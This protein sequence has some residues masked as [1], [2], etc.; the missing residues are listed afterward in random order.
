MASNSSDASFNYDTDSRALASID[1]PHRHPHSGSGS[2]PFKIDSRGTTSS[3]TTRAV[4]VGLVIGVIVSISNIYFGLQIGWSS[5]MSMPSS[6]LGFAAFKA[7]AKYLQLPFTQQENVFVQTVA[8]AVG[9][10]PVTAGLTGVIP[11]LEFLLSPAENGPLHFSYS[12]LLLWSL[13]LCPFGLIWAMMFRRQFVVREPLPW[14]GPVA[15]ATLISVLH[16]N[17]KAS[18][19]LPSSP[20]EDSSRGIDGTAFVA[21]ATTRDAVVPENSSKIMALLVAAVASGIFV[22]L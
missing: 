18:S 6:L 12:Q 8:G 14:P 20:L 4:L 19:G 10:M 13:A 15:T 16:A 5:P 11:A 2:M 22:S 7:V 1:R 17:E 3:L 9:C 21:R